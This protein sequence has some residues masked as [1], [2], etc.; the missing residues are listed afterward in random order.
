MTPPTNIDGTDISGATI[1]GQDVKEITVD[2]Q[3]VFSAIPDSAVAHY[4]T[5]EGSGGT[6]FDDVNDNHMDIEGATWTSTG[7]GGWHLD[8]DGAD[9]Y[10]II[11]DKADFDWT[12]EITVIAWVSPDNVSSRGTVAKK[13]RGTSGLLEY[14]VEIRD[15]N[16][17]I[18]IAHPDS[19]ST[20]TSG[21]SPSNDDWQMVTL[22]YERDGTL[23]GW[24]DKSEVT[25]T[26]APDKDIRNDNSVMHFGATP[27]SENVTY[28]QNFTPDF[29]FDGGIDDWLLT[30]SA[31]S[32]D[33]IEDWY[34]KTVGNYK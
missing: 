34:D 24:I 11:E 3:T 7:R 19:T 23:D 10:T 20:T 25:T 17:A 33:V 1:D 13:G 21:G 29:Q 6:L 26:S 16:L 32:D 8:F 14:S 18:L 27:D 22:R 4:P 28:P 12:G 2:G 5:T 30:N 15:S 9:N 31:L